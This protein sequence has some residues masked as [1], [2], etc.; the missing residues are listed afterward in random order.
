MKIVILDAKTLGGDID[1]SGFSAFG[2]TVIYPMTT[3]D[4]VAGRIGDCDILVLNKIKMNAGNLPYAKKLKLICETATGYDNIDC[5]YCRGHGIGVCNVRGYSTDSVAQITAAM[6]L[7]LV[8]HL[9][10]FDAYVKDNRYTKSGVHNCLTPYFHEISGMTWGIAGMGN[11]GTKVAQIAETLGCR[12]L[13]YKRKPDCVYPCV[14][15]DTLCRESDILSIHLPLT[16]DTRDLFDREH[17]GMMKKNAIFINMARGAVADETA[18]TQA[19][20][21][22]RIG[23]LGIDVF[24]AEPMQADSPYQRILGRPNVVFT[25]HMAWAAHEAR[26]RCIDEIMKNIA[27]FLK[28]EKRNR[29]EG[30]I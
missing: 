2:E 7:S 19:V 23:G 1:L 25:P 18:L 15:L 16:E 22:N 28:G 5:A 24:S 3:P 10:E 11:I 12:V 8:S 21:E 13:A 26:V 14:D 9:P 29:I 30:Q 4:E 27:A 17:I 6:A 20:E